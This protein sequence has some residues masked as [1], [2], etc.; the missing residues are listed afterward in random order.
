MSLLKFLQIIEGTRFSKFLDRR[1][2]AWNA[3]DPN[4]FFPENISRALGISLRLAKI[5][6]D[7]TVRQGMYVKKFGVHCPGCERM[8]LSVDNKKDLPETIICE[9][10]ELQ[11]AETYT[12]PI[13]ECRTIEFY[14]LKK[15]D[16][17]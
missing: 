7:L 3:I 11:E 13:A 16:D 1:T 10:C 14:Q 17:R 2:A 6:C 12:F 5:F 4:K 15:R 8:V 9:I